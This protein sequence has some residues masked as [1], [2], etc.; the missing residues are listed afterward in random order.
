MT[1]AIYKAPALLFYPF[2]LLWSLIY[3]SIAGAIFK[4]LAVY[5]NWLAI[6]RL[7]I[8]LWKKY[9]LRS[10]RKYISSMW[11]HQ[12]HGK[13]LELAEYSRAELEKK[14]P[15]EPFPALRILTNTVFMAF[16]APFMALY[17]LVNGPVY[18]FQLSM[19]RR[20]RLL[21]SKGQ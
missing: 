8:T 15:D 17:G 12:I 5:E 18:V 21:S 2:I 19:E 20:R 3:G 6:N 11:E 13:P 4:L 1:S 9:P 10:Y 14:Y 16:I 7:Q